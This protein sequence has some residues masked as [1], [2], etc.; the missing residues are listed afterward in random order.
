MYLC[1][2]GFFRFHAKECGLR[3]DMSALYGGANCPGAGHPHDING[4]FQVELVRYDTTP[5]VTNKSLLRR[6]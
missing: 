3:D 6:E 4:G 2:I 1:T 5:V